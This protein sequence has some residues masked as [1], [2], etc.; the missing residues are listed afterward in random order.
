MWVW[1]TTTSST[2]NGY[3]AGCERAASRESTVGMHE[4]PL[5]DLLDGPGRGFADHRI[6]VRRCD[7][8]GG[9]SRGVAGV[10]EDHGGIAAEAG[11]LGACQGCV[12]KAAAVL[13]FVHAQPGDEV[14]RF[15][16]RARDKER[17]VARR[18][19]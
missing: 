12:T 4:V 13:L 19:L 9:E 15:K 18:R 14:G 8:Q 17:I 1:C 7:V 16:V 5:L 2:G 3:A 6:V 10:A 11:T